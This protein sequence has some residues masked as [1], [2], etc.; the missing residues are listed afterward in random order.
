ME[1]EALAVEGD[2]SEGESDESDKWDTDPYSEG[3]VKMMSRMPRLWE[4]MVN[5]I[6]MH[7]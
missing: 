2:A 4:R 1:C 7:C 3:E 5:M 6:T